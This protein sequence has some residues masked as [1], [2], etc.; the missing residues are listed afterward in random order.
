VSCT[1]LKTPYTCLYKTVEFFLGFQA[2]SPP[3]VFESGKYEK[4]EGS[5]SF[6]SAKV[7][8]SAEYI[9]TTLGSKAI[10]LTEAE[11]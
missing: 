6:C 8:L 11:S 5:T 9:S 7:T 4:V 10:F 3:F 1:Y 2:G